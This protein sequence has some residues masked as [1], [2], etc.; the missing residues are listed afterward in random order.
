LKGGGKL[1]VIDPRRTPDAEKAD[2]WLQIRPGTD[3]AL[4]LGMINVIIEEGL[5]D[6][7]F[8]ERWCHGF[9]KLRER[10]SEYPLS[11][12]EDITWVPRDKIRDAAVMYAT[13]KPSFIFHSMGLEQ[14]PN[15]E[16][17]YHAR[18]I[19]TAITG[20]LDIRGGEELRYGHPKV[21]SEYEME[22]NDKLPPEQ[23]KKQIGID[24]FRLQSLPGF[25]LV[26]E[27]YA[28]AKY[29]RGH[30][31]FA[32]APSVY[33]AMITG[34]PY[35]VRALITL[36]SNPLLTQAN[37][38]LVY[39]AI[40]SLD[41]YVVVDFWKTPSAEL[42]DYIFPSATWLER[43]VF[44][45]WTDT[46]SFVDCAEAV[47]PARVEG[48]Y[49]RRPDFDFWRGLGIRLGQKEYWP[50]NSLDESFDYRLKPM[51]VSFKEFVAKGG[52]DFWPKEEKKY[53]KKG[54]G[55]PTG[56]VELY[57]EI[58][59]ELDYDPLPRYYEPPESPYSRPDLAKDYPLILITGMRHYPFYHSEHRQISSLR[60]Q[61][62]YPIVQIHPE[63][64]QRYGIKD[65]E[66]VWIET[67][68]GRIRQVCRY[69][70]GIDPRV[71]AAQHGWWYPEMPGEEP[72]LHGVWESNINVVVDDEITH[73]NNLNGG[74]PLRTALCKI[75]KDISF[76]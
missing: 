14:L 23:K 65:G 62:P 70:D 3:C 20:N 8:V 26:V 22:L 44:H 27:K 55:T 46:F 53:E 58:L 73:C 42:A 24:R 43:P 41:L 56:K 16:E 34:K 72:W 50:W 51:G 33:R 64:A 1:I 59:R 9:D 25:D 49:D 10:A 5:Y 45:N 48:E 18:T 11:R 38:K 54:F 37:T 63:T 2:L 36:A 19:L 30:L 74:W 7:E 6:K 76:R 28:K 17:T 67:P 29:A 32:H 75:Y 52:Y 40:K 39:E 47:L 15:S 69:F 61:H 68:R 13:I 21:I 4:A 66:W 60:R 12:V 31:T 35:P 57:S 71:V